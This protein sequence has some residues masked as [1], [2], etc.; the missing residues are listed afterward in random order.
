MSEVRTEKPRS[1]R[2]VVATI[3]LL[4]ALLALWVVPMLVAPAAPEGAEAFAGADAQAVEMVEDTGYEPWFAP[5]FEPSSEVE[6]GIF[7]LQA[8]IGSGVLFFVLGYFHGRTRTERALRAG[9]TDATARPR[10][11]RADHPGSED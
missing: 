6:S 5:V 9:V 3:V 10:E 7:A 11:A 2:G 4:V 1:R 8:A